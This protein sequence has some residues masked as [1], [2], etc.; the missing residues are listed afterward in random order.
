MVMFTSISTTFLHLGWCYLFVAYLKMDIVGASIA[1]S[2]TY[3]LQ[4]VM[5]TVYCSKVKELKKSFFLPTKETFRDL[6]EYLNLAIPSTLML[7][8]DWWSFEILAILAGYISVEV[9]GAHII[10][11]NVYYLFVMCCL[12][13]HIAACV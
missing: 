7:V 1:T 11:L 9:T 8:F 5:I 12:G 6:G 4:F 13:T 2:I 3:F 10:I